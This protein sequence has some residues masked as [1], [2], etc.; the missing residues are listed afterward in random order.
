M[1]YPNGQGNP[2]LAFKTFPK[3]GTM[4]LGHHTTYGDVE[5]DSTDIFIDC[6]NQLRTVSQIF[7]LPTNGATTATGTFI[8]FTL[9]EGF[10]PKHTLIVPIG[11]GYTNTVGTTVW[12]TTDRMSI[13][14]DGSCRVATVTPTASYTAIQWHI[15]PISLLMNIY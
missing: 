15:P 9:P 7:K 11:R 2:K 6:V 14:T 1:P 12:L 13:D 8:L 5:A 3:G 4:T 10:R